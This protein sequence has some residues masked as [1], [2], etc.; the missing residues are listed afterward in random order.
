[1]T[2]QELKPIAITTFNTLVLDT[3]AQS[4]FADAFDLWE[5]SDSLYD[6]SNNA[7]KAIIRRYAQP[8]NAEVARIAA[9]METGATK[10]T[11]ATSDESSK[12]GKT[13]TATGKTIADENDGEFTQSVRKYPDGYVSAPDVAML[14]AETIDSPYTQT[15][16]TDIVSAGSEDITGNKDT[17]SDTEETDTLAR[18][19]LLLANSPTLSRL[20]ESLV[21][22]FVAG[23]TQG[24]L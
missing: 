4:Y 19:A 10:H 9:V 23:T 15:R 11:K 1:M 5:D 21:F 20:I 2:M 18:A 7:H 24:G 14:A 6:G 12:G 8:I 17:S 3:A 22:C 16:Q 13:T